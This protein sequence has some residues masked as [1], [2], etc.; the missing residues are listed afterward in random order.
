MEKEKD[1][2]GLYLKERLTSLQIELNMI[3]MRA[4]VILEELPKIETE[5][6]EHDSKEKDKA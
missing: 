2:K 4:A 1:Y 6:K 5:L 3:N